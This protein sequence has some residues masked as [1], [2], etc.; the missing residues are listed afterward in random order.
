MKTSKEEKKKIKDKERNRTPERKAKLKEY[1]KRLLE[2]HPERF[3][4][5]EYLNHKMKRGEIKRLPCLICNNRDTEGHHYDY[6]QMGKV[7]WLCKRHHNQL[8]SGVITYETI[9]DRFVD[10]FYLNEYT[11]S[12]I[13][14]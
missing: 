7:L 13:L 8:H 6:E 5:R 10:K 12:K 2:K 3:K 11:N 9:T 4:A 1:R 14:K